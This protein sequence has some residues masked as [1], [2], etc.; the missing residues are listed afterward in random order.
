MI[1]ELVLIMDKMSYL[2]ID[3]SSEKRMICA[4][5]C[6]FQEVL[7]PFEGIILYINDT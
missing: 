3:K 7:K 6:A 1:I 2:Q 5:L 4:A